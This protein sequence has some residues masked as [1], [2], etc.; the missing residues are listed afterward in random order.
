ML[1]VLISL[2]LTV[3]ACA[4]F[5]ACPKIFKAFFSSIPSLE[6][7]KVP[8]RITVQ[9]WMA[10]VGY[11]KLHISLDKADD[12]IVIVDESI[13]VGSQKYLVFLGCRAKDLPQGRSLEL[14][15]L[16]PL[17]AVVQTK[18]DAEAIKEALDTITPRV[19]GIL[20]VCSD[21]GSNL[22]NG[23][24]L[25]QEEYPHVLHIPDIVHKLANILKKKLDNNSEWEPFIKQVNEARRKMYNSSSA[26][27]APPALRGKSRFLNLDILVD[28]ASEALD[29]LKNGST[30]PEYDPE[31]AEGYLGWLRRFEEPLK[32]YTNLV[33][34]A[35]IARHLV[36]QRGIHQYI[37]DDFA[38]EFESFSPPKGWD[39]EICGVAAQV[40]DFLEQQG[41]KVGPGQVL[42][43]SS[44]VI[45]SFFGKFKTIQG[46]TKAGFS[47][48]VLAGI[49][50]IGKLDQPTV[51]A[52][53]ETVTHAQVDDWINKN[54]GKT[55]HAKRCE[56][57]GK[58]E[59][60][61]RVIFRKISEYMGQKLT[62]TLGEEAMG[63]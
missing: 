30:S 58:C 52:A 3:G 29:L 4:S 14:A 17:H 13:Q 60:K 12:W 8:S 55:V 1:V 39:T 11:Y 23:F 44:E 24:R 59:K 26:H 18:S 36:R 22:M 42:L 63:F 48:L 9:R 53:I 21:E 28:W 5:R 37:A 41:K 50:H 20:G 10:K 2:R 54:V 51:Q 57:L 49:A 40:Y 45:E 15:D 34:V 47:G 7:V 46:N 31:A 6:H 61:M 27:L 56:L 16:V 25:Y 43:G 33:M 38:M 62:G 19:G 35:S 32:Y